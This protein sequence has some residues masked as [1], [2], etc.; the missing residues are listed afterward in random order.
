MSAT[1]SNEKLTV[2]Q[3]RKI[4]NA[5]HDLCKTY[6]EGIPTKKLN[7]ILAPFELALEDGIY[8]GRQGESLEPIGKN[9]FLKMT[10]YRMESGR[11]E[12]VAYLTA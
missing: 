2:G 7:E 4:G 10:W 5:L 12:I 1:H 6:H 11:F 9:L 8:T 3:K